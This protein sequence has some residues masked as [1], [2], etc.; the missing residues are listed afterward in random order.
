M[1]QGW[2]RWVVLL[3]ALCLTASAAQAMQDGVSDR[4][5]WLR[6]DAR[7]TREAEVLVAGAPHDADAGVLALLG[8]GAV[9]VELRRR[10]A[11]R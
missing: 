6:P 9:L 3:T 10:A 1:V 8:V 2:L 4:P 11:E 5:S 7:V